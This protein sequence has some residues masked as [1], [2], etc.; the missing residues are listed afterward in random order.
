MEV[1]ISCLDTVLKMGWMVYRGISSTPRGQPQA[2]MD[3]SGLACSAQ[4]LCQGEGAG[5]GKLDGFFLPV[6]RT[7][8]ILTGQEVSPTR[9]SPPSQVLPRDHQ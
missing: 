6:W 1:L 9:A 7:D 2:D 3:H 8:G 5:Q 4:D